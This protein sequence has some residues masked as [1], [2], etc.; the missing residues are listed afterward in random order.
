MVLRWHICIFCLSLV[1]GSQLRKGEPK[2]TSS[3]NGALALAIRHK[4]NRTSISSRSA[5]YAEKVKQ[6]MHQRALDYWM[7]QSL[8]QDSSCG[9]YRA[10]AST[11]AP[12][13]R[14][15][16]LCKQSSGC[17]AVCD[18]VQH[19]ICDVSGT[20]MAGSIDIA[21]GAAAAAA[22]AVNAV[23]ETVKDAVVQ[24]G[25]LSQDSSKQAQEEVKTAVDATMK[26]TKAATVDVGAAAAESAAHA[27]AVE[28]AANAPYIAS[29]AS[30]AAIAAAK[31]ANAPKGG[32]KAAPAPAA[33]APAGF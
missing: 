32:A 17:E 26:V 11:K 7:Y 6:G 10:K 13:A 24:V 12:S 2:P 19:M 21:S 1:A 23:K 4:Q 14:C 31:A 20:P 9:T 29:T 22:A 25:R 28:A 16:E 15:I 33:P 18:E 8:R 3:K 5:A 30:S 27:A